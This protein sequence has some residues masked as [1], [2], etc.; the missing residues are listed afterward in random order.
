MRLGPSNAEVLVYTFKDGFLSKVAHDLIL[1]ATA[2]SIEVEEG[3]G[4]I[5]ATVKADSL[6]VVGAVVNGTLNS[7]SLSRRD[8]RKIE[9]N[10]ASAVL[11]S[12]RHPDIVF[13]G[14]RTH[15]STISGSLRLHGRS[16]PTHWRVTPHND[17]SDLCE[18][19]AEIHQPDHGIVPFTALLGTLRVK[20]TVRVVV[21]QKR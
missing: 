17:S 15:E 3:S 19:E 18:A 13:S 6:R 5:E 11:H 12:K 9:A 4:A 8:K 21:R 2:F 10:I 7:A 1:R 14:E 20:P 16:Q